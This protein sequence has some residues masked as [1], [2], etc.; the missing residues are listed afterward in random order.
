M[1]DYKLGQMLLLET[2]TQVVDTCNNDGYKISPPEVPK[3]LEYIGYPDLAIS[4]LANTPDIPFG[5]NWKPEQKILLEE[6]RSKYS[7]GEMETRLEKAEKLEP[8]E[9]ATAIRDVLS[10]Y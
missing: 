6:L 1:K 8:S 9:L 7:Q 5:V 2:W 3:F 4:L 10:G